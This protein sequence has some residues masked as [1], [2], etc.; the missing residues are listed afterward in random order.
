MKHTLFLTTQGLAALALLLGSAPAFAAE[1]CGDGTCPDGFVCEVYPGVCPAIACAEGE[2]CPPCN[3]EDVEACAPAPCSTND[4][5]GEHM[6]CY[7][8]ETTSCPDAPTCAPDEPC[9]EP[10]QAGACEVTH[11]AR[12]TPRWQ[13]PCTRDADCGEGFSCEAI[14]SCGCSGSGGS[15]SAGS[16]GSSGGAEGTA[17]A[18]GTP[19]SSPEPMDP[20]GEV[21]LPPECECTDTG[22]MG[23]ARVET[24]CDADADCPPDWTCE[25]N[26]MGVCWV[27]TD[28][29]SGCTLADPPN[30]CLEPYASVVTGGVP[31]GGPVSSTSGGDSQ[32]PRAPGEG[33]ASGSSS[34]SGCALGS[35]SGGEPSSVGLFALLGLGLLRRRASRAL[36]PSGPA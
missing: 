23:C 8:Y 9:V 26:P 30:I 25:E 28:G 13:L 6:V 11:E 34:S 32:A 35:R 14:E 24:A 3:P 36:R 1:G 2:D 33:S 22:E 15:G 17:G 20:G 29:N 16:S 10:V 21:P 4:D 19:P 5:C 18:A 12:C 27:D 7:E 31:E